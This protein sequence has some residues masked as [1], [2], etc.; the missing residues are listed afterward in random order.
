MHTPS[1]A[2]LPYCKARG[3]LTDAEGCPLA[4]H[5]DQATSVHNSE[6]APHDQVMRVCGCP[7]TGKPPDLATGP[8]QACPVS[9]HAAQALVAQP[10][11]VQRRSS[12]ALCHLP[13][14]SS[15]VHSVQP[16]EPVLLHLEAEQPTS[17]LSSR[18]PAWCP[19]S[20]EQ[21]GTAPSL[22]TKTSLGATLGVRL[23]PAGA[24]LSAGP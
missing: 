21:R 3:R 11:L 24:A 16:V 6:Q 22:L 4:F 1:P 14:L 2:S 12:L 13:Q 9:L 8:T 15:A 20:R 7:G 10:R 23:T 19:A 18:Q 5:A 17:S